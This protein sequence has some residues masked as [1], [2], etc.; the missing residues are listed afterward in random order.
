M[1]V[2]A[3]QQGPRYPADSGLPGPPQHS[4]HH[5]L[6]EDGGGAVRGDLEGRGEINPLTEPRE[7]GMTLDAAWKS[8]EKTENSCS[9]SPQSST[10]ARLLP[11]SEKKPSTN[12][13]ES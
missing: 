13:E 3:G 8:P 7:M 9:G 6:H 12:T 4:A 2:R 1:R 11:K 5:S 10:T